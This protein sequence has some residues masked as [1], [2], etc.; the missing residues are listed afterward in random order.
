MVN[1]IDCVEHRTNWNDTM[2]DIGQIVKI[3]VWFYSMSSIILWLWIAYLFTI[4][5][6]MDWRRV[7]IGKPDYDLNGVPRMEQIRNVVRD[8]TNSNEV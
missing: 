1:W 3:V 8:V 2:D 5:E 6:W 4:R 7:R